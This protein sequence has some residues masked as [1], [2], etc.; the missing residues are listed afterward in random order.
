M[1]QTSRDGDMP[2]VDLVVLGAQAVGKSTFI[3]K[4]LDMRQQ[5]SSAFS[6]KKMS[7]DGVI[8]LVRL[9]E[10]S[11]DDI[12]IVDGQIAWPKYSGD[13]KVPLADGILALYDVTNQESITRIPELLRQSLVLHLK[14]LAPTS[15]GSCNF[16]IL[17]CRSPYCYD[18]DGF[19]KYQMLT[20][21][22]DRCVFQIFYS[23]RLGV[24]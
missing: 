19:A 7:L 17:G 14:S 10:L 23:L 24:V 21:F 3:Q 18:R 16:P 8:Y 15:I 11:F 4:A 6:A 13:L 22:L 1:P 9:V 2:Q 12:S 20:M 5:P